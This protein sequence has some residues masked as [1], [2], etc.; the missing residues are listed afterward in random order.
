MGQ[1]ISK[2]TG[3][4]P[5]S[6]LKPLQKLNDIAAPEIPYES[7]KQALTE[8][9][10]KPMKEVFDGFQTKPFSTNLFWQ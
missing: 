7:V 1:L 3:V 6:V 10:Q 2:M 5:E 9:L 8:G 4:L